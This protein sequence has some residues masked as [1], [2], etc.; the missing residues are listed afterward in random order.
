MA[1]RGSAFQG[2]CGISGVHLLQVNQDSVKLSS[3]LLGTFSP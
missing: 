3:P 2:V 1:S